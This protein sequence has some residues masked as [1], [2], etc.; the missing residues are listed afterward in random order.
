MLML[1]ESAPESPAKG[2]GLVRV[3]LPDKTE[4]TSLEV[5]RTVEVTMSQ[6]PS[7]KDAEPDFNLVDPRRVD[8]RVHEV[9]S[10]AVAPV[11][12]GPYVAAVDVQIVPDDIHLALGIATGEVLHERHDVLGGSPGSHVSED[13]TSA[14]SKCADECARPSTSIL[15]FETCGTTGSGWSHRDPAAQRLNAGLLVDAKDGGPLGWRRVEPA[16]LSD[17]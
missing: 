7:L 10:M 11:E 3:P 1:G 6:H 2:M 13:L 4:E 9:K 17:L 12:V 5:E 16:N 14:D 8:R 15:E